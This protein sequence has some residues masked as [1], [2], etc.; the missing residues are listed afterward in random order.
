MSNIYLVLSYQIT[1]M[2]LFLT[3]HLFECKNLEENMS[4]SQGIDGVEHGLSTMLKQMYI[5]FVAL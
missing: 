4:E 5:I 2:V 3:Q 1:Q